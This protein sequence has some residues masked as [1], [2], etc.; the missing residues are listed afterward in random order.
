VAGWL[1]AFFLV[2]SPQWTVRRL[3]SGR[4]AQIQA[5]SFD[6]IYVYTGTATDHGGHR[7]QSRHLISST[8][9]SSGLSRL[10]LNNGTHASYRAT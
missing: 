7:R 8:Y 3:L 4:A 6:Q 2:R 10:M 9:S 5:F 1:A